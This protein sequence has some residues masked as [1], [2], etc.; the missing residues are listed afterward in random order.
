MDAYRFRRGFIG[1]V[2]LSAEAFL[3]HGDRIFAA[4]PV[5]HIDLTQVRDVDENLWQSPLLSRLSS[6][7]TDAAGCTTYTCNCL[8]SHPSL[9]TCVGFPSPTTT[10]DC[11]PRRRWLAPRPCLE[12]LGAREVPEF[13]FTAYLPRS[14]FL[15]L[16]EV[17]MFFEALWRLQVTEVV[18][19]FDV[20]DAPLKIVEVLAPVVPVAIGDNPGGEVRRP[21]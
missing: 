19:V 15:R 11:R 10:W 21:K 18:D 20:S 14:K 3:A 6:L 12:G 1:W 16:G 5:R 8:P 17:G 7:S 9:Q 13:E 4:A 2:R